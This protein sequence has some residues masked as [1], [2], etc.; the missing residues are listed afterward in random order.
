MGEFGPFVQT[1][2]DHKQQSARNIALNMR[3][4]ESRLCGFL[5]TFVQTRQ[6]DRLS[7]APSTILLRVAFRPLLD[8]LG[9]NGPV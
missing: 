4:F 6:W 3:S 9:L 1:N 8:V 7:N 5:A 2:A